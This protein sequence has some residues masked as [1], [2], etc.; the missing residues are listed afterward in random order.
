MLDALVQALLLM[1][2]YYLGDGAGAG[3]Q[4][5]M[6]SA[7]VATKLTAM[8]AEVTYTAD[9]TTWRLKNRSTLTGATQALPDEGQHELYS[10][11]PHGQQK[12]HQKQ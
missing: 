1:D 3:D 6:R 7:A 9:S 11:L 12:G 2:G 10:W 5:P 8:A 4:T